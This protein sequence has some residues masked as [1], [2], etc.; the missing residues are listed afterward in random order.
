MPLAVGQIIYTSFAKVGYQLLVSQKI[1]EE[2]AESF[3][4]KIV[5]QHW[6]AYH[7]PDANYQAAYLY[8]FAADQTLFGWL[9]NDGTDDIGRANT[10]YFIC[11]YFTQ[12]LHGKNLEHIITCLTKGPMI[13]PERQSLPRNLDRLTIPDQCC[14][15][16]ARSGVPVSSILDKQLHRDIHRHELLQLFIP[17]EF[18]QGEKRTDQPNSTSLSQENLNHF[19]CKPENAIKIRKI[20]ERLATQPIEFQSAALMDVSQDDHIMTITIG[21]DESSALILSEHL[22]SLFCSTKEESSWRGLTQIIARSKA[23]SISL[24][25]CLADSFLLVKTG[26]GLTGLLEGEINRTVKQLQKYLDLPAEN[27]GSSDRVY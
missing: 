8:Q 7:S 13:L 14:Y 12:G 11:Y 20:L 4:Q 22:L 9:Y 24:T 5:Y 18:Q 27:E 6:D 1:P 21:I 2:V 19:L 17:N 23:G 10:P 15:Q 3:L 25:H 16:P 26:R